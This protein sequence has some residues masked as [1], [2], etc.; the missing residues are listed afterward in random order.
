M[1]GGETD[2]HASGLLKQLT[3]WAEQGQEM[4]SLSAQAQ[5]SQITGVETGVFAEAVSAYNAA[6]QE[7]SRLCAQGATQMAS[8]SAALGVAAKKYGA[9]EQQLAQASAA[10]L[11]CPAPTPTATH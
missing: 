5:S 8:I 7:I 10:A 9:N 6:A 3:V 2:Y 11:S 4:G 1:S